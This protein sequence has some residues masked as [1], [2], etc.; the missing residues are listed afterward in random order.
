MDQWYQRNLLLVISWC[1]SPMR[2]GYRELGLELV[3]LGD[4]CSCWPKQPP[5]VEEK[6]DDGAGDPFNMFLE[7]SLCDKRNEMMD[8]FT[9]ILR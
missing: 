6:R 9:Q 5:M 2:S 3:S 8:N 4:D 1:M 7:E